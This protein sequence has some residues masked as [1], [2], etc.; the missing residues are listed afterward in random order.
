M[1]EVD[2]FD[3]EVMLSEEAVE[4]AGV[5]AAEVLAEEN[6]RKWAKVA[7]PLLGDRIRCAI[8]DELAA[9][10]PLSVFAQCWSKWSELAAIPAGKRTHVRLGKHVIEHDF[11]P[12]LSFRLG[13]MVSDPIEFTLTVQ[14]EIESVELK[15]VDRHITRVGGGKCNMGAT[16]KYADQKICGSGA[17]CSYRI[18]GDYRFKN[19]IRIAGPRG[20]AD[21]C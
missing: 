17:L 2:R 13:P 20:G 15:V 7:I 5:K 12:A 14:A 10:D 11:L 16:L 9:F 19:P 8:D 4:A 21:T 3:L 1:I 18:P 6:G